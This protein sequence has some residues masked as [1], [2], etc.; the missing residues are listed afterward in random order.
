VLKAHGTSD[1]TGAD[2]VVPESSKIAE[3]A[4]R[5]EIKQSRDG[6][7]M[8][9]TLNLEATSLDASLPR[10]LFSL[11]AGFGGQ[12]VYEAAPD[13]QHFLVGDIAASP[14]PLTVILNWRAMLKKGAAAP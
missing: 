2:A 12:N 8:I 6:K 4:E 7:L 3:G 10:A 5:K 9:V 1:Q 14:E 11:P 13:G